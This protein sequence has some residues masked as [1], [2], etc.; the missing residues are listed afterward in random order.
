MM[1]AGI[2]EYQQDAPSRGRNP[3]MILRAAAFLSMKWRC[4]RRLGCSMRLPGK[5]C[6]GTCRSFQAVYIKGRQLVA[7]SK[8]SIAQGSPC[9]VVV[10]YGDLRGFSV[11]AN[12]ETAEVVA[13]VL[14]EQCER[15]LQIVNDH[16]PHFYKFLGDG[17][18]LVWESDE[19]MTVQVC[20]RHA[21]D[22]AYYL[23]NHFHH[24]QIDGRNR[25]PLGYGVG[26]SVGSATKVQP[27]TVIAEFNEIDFAGYPLNCGARMQTLAGAYG[28]TLCSTVVAIIEEDRDAFLYPGDPAFARKLTAPTAAA[29]QKAALLRGLHPADQSRFQYMTWPRHNPRWGANGFL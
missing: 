5:I 9:T 24:A 6:M 12:A 18:L 8:R 23:H 22:A 11:W 21:I 2:L 19:E 27:E 20:L 15:V 4:L 25:L 26:I 13:N 29:L 10:M 14:Q 7:T 16:H 17:F 1:V 3:M 28:V